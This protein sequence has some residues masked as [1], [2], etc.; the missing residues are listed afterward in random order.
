M[1]AGRRRVRVDHRLDHTSRA[2]R[3]P[4]SADTAH[5]TV[6]GTASSPPELSPGTPS[7]SSPT[8]HTLKEQLLIPHRYEG[9]QSSPAT[10]AAT[11][12]DS[13]ANR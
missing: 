12:A 4:L 3:R 9:V 1:V 11:I 7:S 2:P 8:V 13:P 6:I 5:T 10:H